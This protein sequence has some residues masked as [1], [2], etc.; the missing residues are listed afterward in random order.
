[1]K[2]GRVA[3]DGTK[4]KANPSKQ[5]AMSYDRMRETQPS[6]LA[7]V[8][9]RKLSVECRIDGIATLDATVTRGDAEYMFIATANAP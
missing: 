5:K 8:A 3:L 2:L 6:P 9:P 7:I 1:L 4:M